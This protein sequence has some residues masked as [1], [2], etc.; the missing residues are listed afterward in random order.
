MKKFEYVDD[1]TSDV[2]FKA[3]GKTFNELLENA[4]LAAMNVMFN[5]KKLKNVKKVIFEFKGDNEEEKL[6]N[7]LTNALITFEIENI[8]IKELKVQGKKATAFGEEWKPELI[9]THVKGVA[10]YNFKVNKTD[11]GWNCQVV[12]DT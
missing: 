6:Y 3:Y 4:G 1:L 2:M 9:E 10:M 7:F 5:T 11:K 12:L 8:M